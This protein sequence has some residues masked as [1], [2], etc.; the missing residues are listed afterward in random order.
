MA[1]RPTHQPNVKADR[2]T[3][4]LAAAEALAGAAGEF[5]GMRPVEPDLRDLSPADASLAVAITRQA[6]QRWL[7]LESVLDRFLRQPLRELEPAVQGVLLGGAAQLLMMN[8]L[9]GYAV[10]DESVDAVRAM[11]RGRNAKGAGGLVN[12][13]LRKIAN[14]RQRYE[15]TAGEVPPWGRAVASR[16]TLPVWGDRKGLMTLDADVLPDPSG[17]GWWLHAAAALSVPAWLLRRWAQRYGEEESVRMG[18]HSSQNPP[19]VVAVEEGFEGGGLDLDDWKIL[20]R[21]GFILWQG[22]GESLGEFLSG[23]PRRRV[24]DPAASLAVAAMADL[25]PR[26]VLD[27]CA[28]RGTKSRQLATLHPDA[29]VIASDVDEPRRAVLREVSR[30]YANLR[31]VHPREVAREVERDGPFDLVLLDVPCSNT[32]VLAR[33]PEARFRASHRNLTELATIQGDLIRHAADWLAPG[34][35][36]VYTTCSIEPEENEA[37]R[38]VILKTIGGEVAKEHLELP[39]GTGATYH[40]GSYHVVVRR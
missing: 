2:R 19:I 26:R 21:A 3:P 22:P 10:V 16:R 35:H 6:V 15:E 36:V 24:Q 25:S 34:G 31:A 28:G 17:E 32:G 13:V 4:R 11:I 39:G 29:Q 37:A 7:T 40:D 30:A 9:P 1:E 23:D 18:L 33:R 27:A 12:A 5:P 14:R 20:E 8:R 38:D